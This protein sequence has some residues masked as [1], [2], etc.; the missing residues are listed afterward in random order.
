MCN[1]FVVSRSTTTIFPSHRKI[2]SVMEKSTITSVTINHQISNTNHPPRSGGK[3][4]GTINGQSTHDIVSK[5]VRAFFNGCNQQ[6]LNGSHGGFWASDKFQY[7]ILDHYRY[8]PWTGQ[9]VN[10]AS[11]RCLFWSHRRLCLRLVSETMFYRASET[12]W[13]L[14]PALTDRNSWESPR[15]IVQWHSSQ[16]N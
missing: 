16:N 2:T 1:W 8:W 9:F 7:I 11:A 14:R 4:K 12:L 10:S 5:T 3:L 15:S 13:V 6:S